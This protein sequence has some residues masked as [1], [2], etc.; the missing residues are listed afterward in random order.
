M[1]WFKQKNYMNTPPRNT[2]TYAWMLRP[3][4][5]N[6]R[7]LEVVVLCYAIFPSVQLLIQGAER[8]PELRLGYWLCWQLYAL[9]LLVLPYVSTYLP[10]PHPTQDD[11]VVQQS[12]GAALLLYC[13]QLL[14]AAALFVVNLVFA[15]LRLVDLLSHCDTGSQCDAQTTSY[16]VLMFCAACQ[17][18][19]GLVALVYVARCKE[20]AQ[21]RIKQNTNLMIRM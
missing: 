12:P 9:L 20:A 19:L 1:M 14:T 5:N 13:V 7:S 18:L 11:Y 3:V 21:L 17:S 4:H 8:V 6:R 15:V 10:T 16:V 2:C